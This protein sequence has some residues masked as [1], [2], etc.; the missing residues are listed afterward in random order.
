MSYMAVSHDETVFADYGLP[1]GGCPAIDC[2]ALAQC[3][4][5]AYIRVGFFSSEFKVLRDTCYDGT[6]KNLYSGTD[7]RTRKYRDVV[8]YLAVITD[9]N[10]IVYDAEVSDLDIVSYPG[11]AVNSI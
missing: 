1:L 10:I 7:T 8:R 2:D 5:I 4:A 3:R 6:R 9:F 11:I